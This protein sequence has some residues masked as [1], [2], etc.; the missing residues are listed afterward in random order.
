MARQPNTLVNLYQRVG[1]IEKLR[2]EKSLKYGVGGFDMP[3][4][5]WQGVQVSQRTDA[6]FIA[7]IARMIDEIN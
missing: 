7:S 4:G 1:L 5:A 2:P 3:F 6:Q